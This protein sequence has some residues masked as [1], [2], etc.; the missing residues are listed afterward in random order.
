MPV[1]SLTLCLTAILTGCV[2]YNVKS[3][4]SG[5]APISEIVGS[6]ARQVDFWEASRTDLIFFGD[7]SDSMSAELETMGDN[8]RTFM[9]HLD[10][11][12]TSWQMAVVTGP[13]GCAVNGTISTRVDDYTDRFAEALVTPPDADAVAEGADEWGLFNVDQ[14]VQASRPG[15]CNEGFVRDNALLHIIVLSDEHDSSPGSDAG[16]DSYWESYIDSIK[17]VKGD[18]YGVTVSGVLG[19]IPDG[20]DGA[21]PGFGYSSA[22]EATGGALLSICDDW[23]DSLGVLV[24]A[25]VQVSDFPLTE[26]PDPDT[27]EVEVNDEERTSGWEYQTNGNLVHFTEALPTLSYT[28][29][30]RY[31]IAEAE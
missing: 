26:T 13:S 28:V 2:E 23:H 16:D 4:G 3:F 18:G 19:P 15:G 1:R 8:A 14:A 24:L 17:D 25:S 10:D 12:D 27:I 21:Y 6:T 5:G 11:Y 22:I 7:T 9:D 30:I 20:C 29:T 31:D